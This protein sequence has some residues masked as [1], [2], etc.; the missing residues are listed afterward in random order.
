M[1]LEN[2]L[3]DHQSRRPALSDVTHLG[4]I[5]Y[6]AQLILSSSQPPSSPPN[7]KSPGAFAAKELETKWL[8][9]I[10]VRVPMLNLKR[11][12]YQRRYRTLQPFPPNKTI[13]LLQS[14]SSPPNCRPCN[15]LIPTLTGLYKRRICAPSM[16]LSTHASLPFRKPPF[17]APK[18]CDIAKENITS[19]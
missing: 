10:E 17:V 7:P 3:C 18:S 13:Q 11:K 5:R 2:N 8:K 9:I 14:F 4:A 6:P 12:A 1:I 19:F 15:L 16:R